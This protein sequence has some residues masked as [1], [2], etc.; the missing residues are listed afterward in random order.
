MTRQTVGPPYYED[1]SVG[2]TFE[3]PGMTITEAHAG[4][5]QAIVGDR[6]RLSL[7]ASLCAEVT[8]A[9]T[10]LA[11]PML[12]CDVAIG[13]STQPSGRV[14]GNLFYRGLAARPVHLGAT[15]RTTTDGRRQAARQPSGR[16]ARG[17]V[18]LHITALDA[19]GHTVA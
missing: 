17:M 19:S 8:A 7:D 4:L 14:L 13:Q 1:L 11:H 15:L 18:L 10:L 12:V 2:Q 5:H 3:A 16:I 6:L 9:P